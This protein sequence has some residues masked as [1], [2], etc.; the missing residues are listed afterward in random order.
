[1]SM[2]F[3]YFCERQVILLSDACSFLSMRLSDVCHARS[4]SWLFA[5]SEPTN[6]LFNRLYS[7]SISMTYTRFVKAY[8]FSLDL[9]F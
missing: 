3:V 5:W 8:Y 4:L 7:T 2:C 9:M 1:M 6:Y